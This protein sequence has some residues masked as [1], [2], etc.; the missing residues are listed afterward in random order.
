MAPAAWAKLTLSLKK[1]VPRWISAKAPVSDPA[2]S[3]AQACPL[4]PKVVTSL[5]CA[6]R[7]EAIF[8][9]SPNNLLKLWPALWTFITVPGVTPTNNAAERALRGPEFQ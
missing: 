3:A 7:G 4:S 1:Q 5:T 2:G 9:P 8:G 6:V